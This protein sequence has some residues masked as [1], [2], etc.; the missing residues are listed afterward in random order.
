MEIVFWLSAGL[1]L[2]VFV[3]YPAFAWWLSRAIGRGTSKRDTHT[4]S[5]TV[6]IAAYN[7]ARDIERTV[8]NK[9]EQDYPPDKLDVLVV[10]DA[11]TDGTDEIVERLGRRVASPDEVRA[12]LGLKG[13]QRT[14]FA[15]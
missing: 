5:V 10:S 4:P 13:A 15:A 7:E 14:R 3:G 8:R 2:Y 9:L 1:V 6:L 11:S 12:M